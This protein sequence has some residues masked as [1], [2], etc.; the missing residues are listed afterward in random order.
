MNLESILFDDF[1][2][3]SRMVE[4]MALPRDRDA[5]YRTDETAVEFT[6]RLCDSLLLVSHWT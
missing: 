1:D 3:G 6:K 2:I 4:V 5:M